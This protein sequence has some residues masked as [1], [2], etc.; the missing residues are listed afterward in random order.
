MRLKFLFLLESWNMRNQCF[1]QFLLMTSK[2]HEK[3]DISIPEPQGNLEVLLR[4]FQGK[5]FILITISAKIF[6]FTWKPGSLPYPE[7]II[8]FSS[9]SK[10]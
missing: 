10:P 8:C 7:I 6:F 3:Y 9:H 5:N 4:Y 2:I 1:Y